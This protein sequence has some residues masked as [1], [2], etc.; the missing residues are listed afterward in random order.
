[1]QRYV[2]LQDEDRILREL[3]REESPM[4]DE[5]TG[6]EVGD[7]ESSDEEPESLPDRVRRAT[8]AVER[9]VITRVLELVRWNRR[10]AAEQLG[11]SYKTLLNKTK[12]LGLDAAAPPELADTES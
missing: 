12:A 3:R 8:E 6:R 1:M 9:Q 11:V 5:Q 10:R 4:L 7:P 2:I